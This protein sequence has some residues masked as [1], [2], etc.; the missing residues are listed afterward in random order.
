VNEVEFEAEYVPPPGG[1]C[2]NDIATAMS[3]VW[4]FVAVM[5]GA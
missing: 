1:R 3:W 2:R 4:M 5:V